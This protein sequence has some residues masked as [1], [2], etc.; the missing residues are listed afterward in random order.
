MKASVIIPARNEARRISRTLQ[1]LKAQDYGNYEIIVVVNASSDNTED[2]AKKYADNVL[3]LEEGGVWRA[4]NRGVEIADGDVVLFIDAD[5]LPPKDW[6]S[7]FVR[8]FRENRDV[9]AAGGLLMPTEKGLSNSLSFRIF[10]WRTRRSRYAML[11]GGNSAFRRDFFVKIGGYNNSSYLE[12]IELSVRIRDVHKARAVLCRDIM[13]LTSIRNHKGKRNKLKWIYKTT[14][15]YRKI[16]RRTRE[17][18]K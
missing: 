16:K 17:I 15:E 11:F 18:G 5:T 4:R 13:V 2:V 14:R 9:Q 1:A 3:V 7:S 8:V 6:I 10:N 12:D